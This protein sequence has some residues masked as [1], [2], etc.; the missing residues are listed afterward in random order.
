MSSPPLTHVSPH[1]AY[2]KPQNIPLDPSAPTNYESGLVGLFV[3]NSTKG[4]SEHGTI[5]PLF[6]YLLIYLFIVFIYFAF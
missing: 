1:L 2:P 6:I 5:L 4:E 3:F